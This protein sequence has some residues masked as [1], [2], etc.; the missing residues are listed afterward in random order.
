MAHIFTRITGPPDQNNLGTAG[1][2]NVAPRGDSF[3]KTDQSDDH[4]LPRLLK[5]PELYHRT[6]KSPPV[7]PILDHTNPIYTLTP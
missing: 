4:K 2:A 5:N 7:E 1:R 6:Y 3:L